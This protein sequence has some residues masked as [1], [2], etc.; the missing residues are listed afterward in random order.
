ME[1]KEI[2]LP[3]SSSYRT[4]EE[5]KLFLSLRSSSWI[6][7][8]TV[9]MRNGNNTMKDEFRKVLPGS[10]RTYEEWKP[11]TLSSFCVKQTS[12]YRTYEEWKQYISKSFDKGKGVLTVPMRNG[13]CKKCIK[14]MVRWKFLPY[15]WGMETLFIISPLLPHLSSYRT[16]EEWKLALIKS[17]ANFLASSYRTY[18]EWK[19]KIIDNTWID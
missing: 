3:S 5:W 17:S 13:N 14:R 6:F 19:H 12:S 18:E 16:Y 15:L 7:V 11:A 8:L 1:R 2:L 9:P 10:Y 4:Y